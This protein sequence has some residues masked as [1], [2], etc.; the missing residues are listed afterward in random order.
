MKKIILSLAV[1]AAMTAASCSGNKAATTDEGADIKAKI[2]NCTNPDSLAIYVEQAKAYAAKLQEE[3][4]TTDADSYLET[5]ANA[6]QE[7][8]PEAAPSLL[9]VLKG[10]AAEVVDAAQQSADSVYNAGAAAVDSAKQ[11]VEGAVEGAKQAGKDAVDQAKQGAQ[12]A[13]Q[14]AVDDAKQKGADAIQAGADKLKGA[15]GK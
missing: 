13:A 12:Q 5:V 3:G 7:K 6:I 15:L 4:K 8:A 2:E 1:L 11:A 14:Q 10:S 9:E